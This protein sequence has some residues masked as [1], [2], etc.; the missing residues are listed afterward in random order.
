M[1]RG[2]VDVDHREAE[3]HNG[4]GALMI[5]KFKLLQAIANGSVPLPSGY[6]RPLRR[7]EMIDAAREL[8]EQLGL[9]DSTN[10]VHED[11]PQRR[12]LR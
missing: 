4:I 9:A 11:A 2:P 3:Y 10:T 8:C 5:G 6:T 12:P 1:T 7:H